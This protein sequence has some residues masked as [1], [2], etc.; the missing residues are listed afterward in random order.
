M[1]CSFGG[2]PQALHAL[3]QDGITI[4]RKRGNADLFIP[5]TA[6]PHWP[7]IA[8]ALLPSQKSMDHP[9][10]IT[11][12]FKLKLRSLLDNMLKNGFLGQPAAHM[13]IIEFQKRG[14][15]HVHL[16]VIFAD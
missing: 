7:E 6:K 14:P 3:Y 1:P 9:D 8:A 15:P 16:L 10:L 12:V 13:Y 2:C 5:M 4:T 11:C